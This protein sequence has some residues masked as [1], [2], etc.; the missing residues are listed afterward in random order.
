MAAAGEENGGEVRIGREAMEP[1]QPLGVAA[2][3]Q[4]VAGEDVVGDDGLEAHP[5]QGREAVL[6]LLRIDGAREGG[7]AA[8]VAGAY[9]RGESGWGDQ[10]AGDLRKPSSVSRRERR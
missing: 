6:E 10:S 4:A 1:R 3:E 8:G 2:G 5:P 9:G 7:H